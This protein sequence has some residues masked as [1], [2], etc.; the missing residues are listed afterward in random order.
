[1]RLIGNAVGGSLTSRIISE[2]KMFKCVIAMVLMLATVSALAHDSSAVRFNHWLN[3]KN[4]EGLSDDDLQSLNDEFDERKK[5][6]DSIELEAQVNMN[7]L[8][9]LIDD[10]RINLLLKVYMEKFLRQTVRNS[11]VRDY[12]DANPSEFQINK[13]RVSHILLR[14]GVDEQTGKNTKRIAEEILARIQQGESFES[15]ASTYSHDKVSGLKGGLLGWIPEGY[16]NNNFS[17]TVFAMA[18][19]ELSP[20]FSTAAGH[21]VVRIEKSAKID[22]IAFS[23][24]KEKIRKK[25]ERQAER[26]EI[27]RLKNL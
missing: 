6:A 7:Q 15:L 8:N 5:I 12:Y 13:I 2:N 4:I 27:R 1:M 11:D 18:E 10:Y 16:I 20:V 25:L 26:S 23:L 21:H 14:R 3:A 22:V 24:V 9:A 17:G 19:G